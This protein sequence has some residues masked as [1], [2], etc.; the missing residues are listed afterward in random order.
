MGSSLAGSTY[1]W[2]HQDGTWAWQWGVQAWLNTTVRSA[3]L[4]TAATVIV[5]G[6]SGG[7]QVA[8]CE[9]CCATKLGR[10][11]GGA[12][13]MGGG[14]KE[15]GQGP[16]LGS[17]GPQA[18]PATSEDGSFLQG[19][20]KTRISGSP[21]LHAPLWRS[22]PARCEPCRTTCPS[23]WGTSSLQLCHG[24][25]AGGFDWGCVL[26]GD[27]PE[28]LR[29]YLPRHSK[30][31]TANTC[32][33]PFCAHAFWLSTAGLRPALALRPWLTSWNL[34]KRTMENEQL[35][36]HVAQPA[37]HCLITL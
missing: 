31:N 11:G 26:S 30:D 13:G 23:A 10:M 16:S 19:L 18:P 7:L 9:R 25:C 2:S 1:H 6:L 34:A 32:L 4:G 14:E 20:V 33:S 35:I 15:R 17:A 24:Q 5:V 21:L 37:E 29:V 3:G 36:L 28:S 8:L 12:E 22:P 27:W